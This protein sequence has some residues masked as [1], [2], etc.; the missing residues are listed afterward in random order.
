MHILVRANM[1]ADNVLVSLIVW[2]LLALFV[3]ERESDIISD[4]DRGGHSEQCF[5]L[6]L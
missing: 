3:K 2:I 1:S 5:R 6:V 4:N